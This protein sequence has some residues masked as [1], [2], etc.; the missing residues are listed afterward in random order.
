VPAHK[1]DGVAN[2]SRGLM[3]GT[4]YQSEY[5]TRTGPETVITPANVALTGIISSYHRHE[6]VV[7]TISN[8]PSVCCMR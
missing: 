2:T 3:K 8:Y 1:Y 7:M 6:L 5:G 4:S